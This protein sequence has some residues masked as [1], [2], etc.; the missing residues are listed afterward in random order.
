MFGFMEPADLAV[1]AL[2]FVLVL[3]I[4]FFAMWKSNRS[5]VSGYF[6][7]GRTMTWIAIGASLFV[8]NIG[9]EHFI[10]L[11]GSGAAS[12]FAVGAWE[13][14][15]VLLL[16]L[17]GW[18]FIPV[19]I[20]SGVFTMPQYLSK[21]YGG[22]RIKVYFA[23]LFLTL[24]VFTKLSV[25]LYAGA[26]FI[27]ASL[28][29]D[30]YLSIIILIGL[31]AVLTVTG[32]LV[33]VIYTDALQAILMI[34]GALTL[35]VVG[36]V[37]VGGFE[38]L[39]QRYMLAS[40]NVTT[41]LASFNLSST[42]T[43]RI[44]P[45]DDA[46]KMLREPTDEDIPWPGFL[47]GQTPVSAWYWCADQVIVQRVLAAK[48]IAH[49]K[50]ATLMA[51]FLKL[52]PMFIIVVPGMISRVLFTDEIIC[53]NPEHCMQVCG[54]RAGCSNIAYPRLVLGI[55]PAGLRGL[56][57]SVMIAAL[58]SDLDSIFNSAST[59]FTL[60]IY[61]HLRKA[62]SSREL[63][64]VGRLFV[65][66][67]V[68]VS[69]AWVPVI[70]EM[71]GGQMYLY[72]QEV[73]NYLTPPVAA[74]FLLGIFWKRCNEKGAFYGGLVGSILGIIRLILAFIYQAP[75]C[76]QVDTRPS[77]IRNIHYMYVSTFLFWTT[78]ITAIVV[79]LLTPA[80]PR[81]FTSSTMFW[82]LK[83]LD[84]IKSS[85]KEECDKL[86]DQTITEC[87][88]HTTSA[89]KKDTDGI[90]LVLLTPESDDSKSLNSPVISEGQ[91]VNDHY[92]NGQT[93][94]VDPE[95]K[96]EPELE[97]NKLWKFFDCLCGLKNYDVKNPVARVSVEDEMICIQMLQ[98]SQKIKV[99]LNIGLLFV[100]SCGISMYLYFSL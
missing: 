8:S 37:K 42:N 34:G 22:N 75:D 12:G 64:I 44:H 49:A 65:V 61:K 66:F 95:T 5:T 79:S 76:D 7:A 45:K 82:A 53:I 84:T 43:C 6:L 69:I 56:M 92:T 90:E 55:L 47:F 68:A 93:V 33:A 14:N 71:Q 30:L 96:E 88:G 58:M 60:D 35:M 28:G 17:L 97:R 25:D 78:V 59:I 32:G 91:T 11:A 54:S 18:V 19:Y 46:L 74:L 10:G 39:K 87:N 36:M 98:E 21:R 2:Y 83:D 86:T 41:V 26:L 9:S 23:L 67:M 20:R 62:A 50:G 1:V 29:W 94:V 52:L 15:A 16:Q 57:M 24:Y 3:C 4:G 51:G 85:Q 13:F 27:R 99:L 63:M 31:T 38:E 73:A 70:V 72:I 81:T 100:L 89:H 40:P 77:F 48:N 80:L